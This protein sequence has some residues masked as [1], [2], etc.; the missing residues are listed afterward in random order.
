MAA[1]IN[2]TGGNGY[3]ITIRNKK[4][5]DHKTVQTYYRTDT[6]SNLDSSAKAG[7]NRM[8]EMDGTSDGLLHLGVT[9]AS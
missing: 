6:L 1:N 8:Q 2:F 5:R 7:E 3:R 9:I 4:F